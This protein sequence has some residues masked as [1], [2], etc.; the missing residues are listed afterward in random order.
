MRTLDVAVVG[1]GVTGLSSALHLAERGAGRIGVFDRTGISAGASG[2]QPG[3]IRQQWGTRLNCLLARRSFAFYRDIA[4]RLEPVADPGFRPCG[5]AFLAHEEATL[6]RFRAEV[7]LQNEL[8]IATR[9][10]TPEEAQ[11]AVPGLVGDTLVGATFNDE[12]GYFDRPQGVVEAFAEAARRRGV[13]FELAEATAIE[14]VGDGWRVRFAGRADVVAGAVVVAAYVD[15]VPLVRSLGVELPIRPEDRHLF[16]SESI[17]ERLLEPLVIAM[18]RHF[19]AKHLADGRVLTSDLSAE[20]DPALGRDRWREHIRACIRELLPQL[21]FVELPL[22]VG[23]VYDMTPDHQPI[24]DGVPGHDGVF[25]AAGFSGHGFMFAP[26]VGEGVAR[27]V[28]GEGADELIGE[29]GFARFE[30]GR[31]EPEARVI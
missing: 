15:S 5:Y 25:V 7:S 22:L 6:E 2:V 27:L 12:D 10:L 29:L 1:A 26:V 28:L 14:R 3:G 23:G 20:G 21:E 19:A 17:R 30:R 11:D 13:V 18:D 4:A 24:V 8:G 31:L 16:L 9:L